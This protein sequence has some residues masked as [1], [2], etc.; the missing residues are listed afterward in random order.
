MS[1]YTETVLRVLLEFYIKN[2]RYRSKSIVYCADN[3]YISC[4]IY[5]TRVFHVLLSKVIL[6]LR[7]VCKENEFF[8][9]DNDTIGKNYLCDDGMHLLHSEKQI[10][11]D[12]FLIL[13]KN[14]FF[15][16]LNTPCS[17]S[18]IFSG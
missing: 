12:N 18:T 5:T 6:K 11:A 13:L 2:C 14:D 1:C 8:F 9:V 15:R 16:E 17:G 10:L 7:P 4:L 3:I